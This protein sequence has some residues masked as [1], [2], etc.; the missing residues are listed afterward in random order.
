MLTNKKMSTDW[1]NC[2]IGE[3][4]LGHGLVPVSARACGFCSPLQHISVSW[5]LF[6]GCTSGNGLHILIAVRQKFVVPYEDLGTFLQPQYQPDAVVVQQGTVTAQFD[7]AACRA[8]LLL[9]APG[10]CSTHKP[11]LSTIQKHAMP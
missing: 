7:L 10:L 1:W 5:L 6:Q 9:P 4:G 3:C 2:M 11:Y 8:V